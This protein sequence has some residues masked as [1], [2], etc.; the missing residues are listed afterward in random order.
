MDNNTSL[1]DISFL[2]KIKLFK[3]EM[4]KKIQEIGREKTPEYDATG[5]QII[6]VKGD[7]GYNY[8]EETFMRAKLDEHFPGW[9]MEMAAPLHFLGAEWIVAQ[10]I[11]IVPDESLL[12]FNIVPPVRKFYGVDSVRIQYKQGT[13]HIPSNIVDVGDNCKQAVTSALKYAINRLT[14]IGD[15]VYGKRAEMGEGSGSIE[16]IIIQSPSVTNLRAF[17][18]KHNI[19]ESRAFEILGIKSY[20]EIKDAVE[21]MNMIKKARRMV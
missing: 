4:T 1:I 2:E 10:I 3:E 18:K 14:R 19:R 17:L 11:L 6:K 15:D 9:S 13:E 20:D 5:K 7:T 12:A 16:D 21:A 8:I